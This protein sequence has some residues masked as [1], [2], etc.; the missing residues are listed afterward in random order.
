MWIFPPARPPGTLAQPAAARLR[1]SDVVDG[2]VRVIEREAVTPRATRLRVAGAGVET[3]VY[4]AEHPLAGTRTEVVRL[5]P[6][7]PLGEWCEAE[8]IAEGLTGGFFAKPDNVPL[9]ELR[10]TRGPAGFKPFAGPWGTQ[11]ACLHLSRHGPVIVPHDELEME[12]DDVLLQA[13]PLLVRHGRLAVAAED[14][15]GFASTAGEEFD[16]DFTAERLPRTAI[17]LTPT[18]WLAVAAEGRAPGEPGLLLSELAA[19]LVELGADTALNLDG[20]SS[21]ALVSGGEVRNHPRDDEGELLE[22]A[23]PT[24]T[25]IAFLT[26]AG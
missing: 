7:R 6:P 9:G 20:G 24:T 16:Q 12:P 2:G 22:A 15:E 21:S 18:S 1:A 19:L 25:A 23:G 3:T 11:R 10:P 17:G 14:P 5:E 8:G 26:A 4:V 13:G